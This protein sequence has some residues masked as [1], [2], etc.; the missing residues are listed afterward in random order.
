MVINSQGRTANKDVK[1]DKR[2]DDRRQ[3]SDRRN[4]KNA[5]RP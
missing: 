1:E 2:K 5:Y 3:N 4:S